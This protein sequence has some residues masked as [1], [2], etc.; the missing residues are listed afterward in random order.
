[1]GKELSD[2]QLAGTQPD[3]KEKKKVVKQASKLPSGDIVSKSPKVDVMPAID[4]RV[5]V[6]HLL[7][8]LDESVQNAV[9]ARR[10]WQDGLENWYRQYRG[11]VYEKSFPW[12]GCSNLH[13]PITGILV[14]T[15]TSRMINPLFS[16][17]PFVTAKGVSAAGLPPDLP[18]NEGNPPRPL[19]DHDKARDVEN[20][21]HYVINQRINVYPKVQDWI[22]EAFIYGRSVMKIIWRKDIR[23]Y[24]RHMSQRDVQSDL[25]SAQADMQNGN[26]TPDLLEFLDQMTF[27]AQNHD[28]VNHP[29]VEVEREEVTY[30]NPDWIFIPIEDFIYHPRAISIQDSPYVAHRFK[31]DIDE[32][33]KEQDIGVYTNVDLLP[34]GLNN[35]SNIISHHGDKLLNDVQTLEEGYENVSNEPTDGL[36]NIEIIEWHGKYDI[37]GDGRMEDIVATFSPGA[38]V[39]LSVRES[40]LLHGKKPF[41]EIKPFPTPGRFESQGVPELITDLQ[42]EIND[43]H[44]MRIDNGTITNAVMWWFDPNSDIDPEIHRPGPGQGFPAGPNQFGVVQ[45]GDIKHSSFKEEELVRRLIQDR[46][47]VSDFAIGNDTSAVANKTATGISAIVN[48]GNQRLEMMLRNVSLGINEAVLQ[49]FQLIQQFSDDEILF[50]AVEDAKGS[51]RKVTSRDIIGQWDIELTA[52]TVNTNRLIKLQ[53]L[54]QQLELAM[55]AGPEHINVTPLLKEF[56]MRSGSK[57]TDEIVLP[58]VQSVLMQ[59]QGNPDLLMMLKQQVDAI[60][61]QAGLIPPDQAQGAEGVPPTPQAPMPA[62]GGGFDWQGLLQQVAPMLQQFL[63]GQQQPQQPQM[64]P[65]QPPQPPV[66]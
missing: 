32:L 49:T 33:Y 20:M 13:V 22:R 61:Q 28:F 27:I 48:E 35:D 5:D 55:R 17:Q 39:L 6:E 21:L 36:E 57:I 12:D 47:G 11:I 60:A 41:A 2:N 14:E 10:E 3:L 62:Q 23:K 44:N 1:M 56:F 31:R 7:N 65:Q 29:F 24:T 42:Q 43:I 54:Q 40:D 9:N 51:L 50:R 45:T 25:Q 53:E 52:N 37:D 26:V 38:K 19:S 8:Y 18:P 4:K 58:E 34:I 64:P 16:A 15:L 30:N 66:Q 59:A 46:I 63:G